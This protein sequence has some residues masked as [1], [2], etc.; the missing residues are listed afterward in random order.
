M[1]I[2]NSNCLSSLKL[3]EIFLNTPLNSF[4]VLQSFFKFSANVEIEAGKNPSVSINLISNF[5]STIASLFILS[6]SL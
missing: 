5:T 3:F 1:D 6:L 4:I 2:I